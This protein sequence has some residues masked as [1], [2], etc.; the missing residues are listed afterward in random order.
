MLT[1]MVCSVSWQT[2]SAGP[3]FG[4]MVLNSCLQTQ[5]SPRMKT[6]IGASDGPPPDHAN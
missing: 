1:V 3:D 5:K 6:D 2:D 4:L